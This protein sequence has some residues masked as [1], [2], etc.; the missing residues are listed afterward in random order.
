MRSP[1]FYLAYKASLLLILCL[2]PTLATAQ[3]QRPLPS[4]K[5]ALEIISTFEQT[6]D[7]HYKIVHITSGTLQEKDGF[8]AD[9]VARITVFAPGR[10]D[11][12][13]TIRGREIKYYTMHWSP[14]YGWYLQAQRKD[15]RGIYLEISSQTRGRVF[16]R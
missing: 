11:R 5:D 12:N 7:R 3:N 4:E 15:A 16:V 1:I 10:G 9:Q 6:S 13:N 2:V 14:T 8:R